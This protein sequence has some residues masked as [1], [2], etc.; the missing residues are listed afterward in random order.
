M[1]IKLSTGEWDIHTEPFAGL[2]C[3]ERVI[4]LDTSEGIRSK[5]FLN[6]VVHEATHASRR[7]LTEGEVVTLATDIVEVLWK[8][9]Y[10]IR[11]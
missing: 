11:R 4:V 8:M 1:T 10:R 5:D 2:T 3:Y 6:T 7:D 9:G